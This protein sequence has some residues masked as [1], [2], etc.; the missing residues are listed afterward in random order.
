MNA[1]TPFD[2]HIVTAM[3]TNISCHAYGALGHS[4]KASIKKGRIAWRM[5]SLGNRD[6]KT[7]PITRGVQVGAIHPLGIAKH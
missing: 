7:R 3:H 4:T 5:S 2:T 1:D 6:V